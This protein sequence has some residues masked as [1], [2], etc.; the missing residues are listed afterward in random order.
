MAG[1]GT[2]FDYND[3]PRLEAGD[4]GVWV[5]FLKESLNTMLPGH[6]LSETDVFDDATVEAVRD[7]QRMLDLPDDGVVDRMTWAL[8]SSSI[9][10]GDVSDYPMGRI[11]IGSEGGAIRFMQG[12]LKAKGDYAGEVTGRFDAATREAL[13]SFHSDMGASVEHDT[14]RGTWLM[15]G[16]WG[17]LHDVPVASDLA[18]GEPA[19]DDDGGETGGLVPLAIRG[20]F[21]TSVDDSVAQLEVLVQNPNPQ[22]VQY[23]RVEVLQEHQYNDETEDE[24]AGNDSVTV[25]IAADAHT[26]D[27]GSEGAWGQVR[28]A[29]LNP[30]TGDWTEPVEQDFNVGLEYPG[31][32]AETG[33]GAAEGAHLV[34][35][36]F[37]PAD[38]VIWAGDRGTVDLSITLLNNGGM[39]AHDATLEISQ[40]Q[41]GGGEV[42]QRQVD[43][44][45]LDV[46]AESVEQVTIDVPRQHDEVPFHIKV[47]WAAAAG[48]GTEHSTHS[49]FLLRWEGDGRVVGVTPY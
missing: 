21:I 13:R 8:I 49:E 40:P 20:V 12:C 34:I 32:I 25:T 48:H 36:G 11:A 43:Q 17:V 3:A 2:G 38:E 45:V 15:L 19:A 39:P 46:G 37:E 16:M 31:E 6:S 23:V 35:S 47:E 26:F 24:L 27:D 14:I 9:H 30:A 18:D 10:L 1:P 29:C 42:T 28:V 44:S 22:A 7:A 41:A 4:T 33:T 5:A